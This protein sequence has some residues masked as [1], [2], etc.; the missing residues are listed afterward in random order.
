MDFSLSIK[1]YLDIPL[2]KYEKDFT[3]IVNDKA[4]K[5]SRQIA[6]ILSPNLRKSHYSDGSINEITINPKEP[7]SDEVDYFQDFLKLPTNHKVTLDFQHKLHFAEY[8]Y[9]LGNYD[10]FIVI[11]QDKF[12]K[13]TIDNAIDRLLLIQKLAKNV[14]YDIYDNNKTIKRIISFISSNFYKFDTS[15]LKKLPIEFKK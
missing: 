14:P 6:D 8:F 2:D 1:N 3:F 5:T 4:Y 11:Q 10:E 13:L 15:L 12:D 9:L 7:Q